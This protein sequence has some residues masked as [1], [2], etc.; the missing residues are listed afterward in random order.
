MPTLAEFLAPID[1]AEFKRHYRG[2]KPLHISGQGKALA[3]PLSWNRL[4]EILELQQLWNED[5]LKVFYQSR[6]ALRENYCDVSDATPGARAPADPRKVKALLGFGASLVAN[7]VQRAAPEVA[8][9]TRMLQRAFACSAG[10][11]VYCSFQK[12][13]A[14]NTHFDLHDVFAWQCEG[15][16]LWRIYEACADNPVLPV[17]PGD[18]AEQ[19][20]IDSRG[21]LLAEVL[22]RPGDILYLP[23]GQYHDALTGADASLHVT[24]WVKPANGL[25]LFKLLEAAAGADSSFRAD[26]PDAMDADALASHLAGLAHRLEQLMLSESFAIDVRN[27]QRSFATSAAGFSLPARQRSQY[28][29][30]ARR[31]PVLRRP[32][33]YSVQIEQQVVNVGAA[34]AAVDWLLQQRFFAL[35]DLLARFHAVDEAEMRAVLAR[36]VD[37]GAIAPTELS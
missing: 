33:G 5:T 22:M 9:I 17:P 8:D 15:E 35:D 21:K 13:Q 34:H 31:G 11:N 23:R 10:A 37:V 3:N 19:W 27:H 7:Q 4:N 24:F 12:V 32:Q 26:L 14:F 1:P 18:E 16:K 28:Y 2:R 29:A 20:L 25:A 6:V 30:V 36:L